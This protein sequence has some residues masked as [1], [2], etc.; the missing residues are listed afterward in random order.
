[1][2]E[3]FL[4]GKIYFSTLEA[5]ESKF[6][7]ELENRANYSMNL[8]LEHEEKLSC[9]LTLEDLICRVQHEPWKFTILGIHGW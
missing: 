6:P 7:G 9:P 8:E 5:L 2:H 3:L 4:C 1:M